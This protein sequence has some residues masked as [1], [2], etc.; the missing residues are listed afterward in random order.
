M[1]DLLTESLV[2]PDPDP[3][4]EVDFFEEVIHPPE[5]EE[6][7]RKS[8]NLVGRLFG[9]H[10][11]IL[12]AIEQVA[13]VSINV[14]GVSTEDKVAPKRVAPG[15]KFTVTL[16]ARDTF[17]RAH[18]RL[19]CARR[20]VMRL[21]KFPAFGDE[22]DEVHIRQMR[23]SKI[24]SGK[25]RPEDDEVDALETQ[26]EE[27]RIR[28]LYE[29]NMN[30]P[31][32]EGEDKVTFQAKVA[33]PTGDD[34]G[35]VNWVKRIVNK[36]LTK[37][38]S[39]KT[40]CQVELKER[41]SA[42]GKDDS[43][44]EI[45]ANDEPDR[46][47]ARLKLC[48]AEAKKL[49][50]DGGKDDD[51]GDGNEGNASGRKRKNNSERMEDRKKAYARIPTFLAKAKNNAIVGA[52][53]DSGILGGLPKPFLGGGPT[54]P[55]MV[56]SQIPSS[57]QDAGGPIRNVGH[58]KGH[59]FNPVGLGGGMDAMGG[60][61][62]GG[63]GGHGSA[64]FVYN[65][66]PNATEVDLYG[67]FGKFGAI[68]KV[69]IPKS[70]EGRS[71]GYGFVNFNNFE[72]A[73]RA[74]SFLDGHAYEKNGYKKLQVSFKTSKDKI[75]GGGGGGGN[76]VFS[77]SPSPSLM[78]SGVGGGGGMPIPSLCGLGGSGDGYGGGGIGAGYSSYP[79]MGMDYGLSSSSNSSS[80]SLQV[81]VF[82][83]NIGDETT[84]LDLFSLCSPF[85]PVS[86]VKVIKDNATDKSKGFAFVTFNDYDSAR[87]AIQ[88]LNG[89]PYPKNNY[90]KL[91]VSFKT[92]SKS[93]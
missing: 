67:L 52:K 40:G 55:L 5:L 78:G 87:N 84:E 16:G 21:W 54:A 71:K 11:L 29:A 59:R 62:G 24:L 10:R 45:Q 7:R 57:P 64:L 17:T 56:N 65:L 49:F 73:S 75:G 60:G 63:V 6:S 15:D 2:L 22:H 20:D 83:Y 35:G 85:G 4:E 1:G 68:C 47:T 77:H 8:T 28:D 34:A 31:A 18:L 9:P 14:R 50:A 32:A 66:G 30:L 41:S 46:A 88:A 82:V 36:G 44:L 81:A 42:K 92:E 43:H 74:V 80:G 86:N 23:L 69:D 38:L 93:K 90:R 37:K 39:L 70:N 89:H 79:Q 27:Q 61:G 58:G 26:G 72:D 51:D 33:L 53:I 48:M 3:D 19:E 76:D 25:Y 91:Q 12:L 13:G